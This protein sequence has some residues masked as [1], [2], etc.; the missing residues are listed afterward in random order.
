MA[1]DSETP[2]PSTVKRLFRAVIAILALVG[3]V[4]LGGTF[5][6]YTARDMADV[7]PWVVEVVQAHFAAVIGLPAAAFVAL[8]LVIF[9]EVKSGPIE[10]KGLGFEFRGA[11]GEITLWV[12]TF[13]SIAAAI[14]LL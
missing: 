7:A 2:M 4:I 1:T 10:F 5:V 3:A 12:V 9:L 14:K 8:C 6:L 13:L 11:S